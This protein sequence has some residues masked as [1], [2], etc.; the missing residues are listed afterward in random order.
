MHRLDWLYQHYWGG[1]ILMIIF[2]ILII[3]GIIWLFKNMT[4]TKESDE[5]DMR[6]DNPEEVAR[7][8]YA[9]G[10]IDKEELEE[11]LKNLKK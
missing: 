3:F 7:R 6:N 1:S 8:R 2:W 10:E 4:N 5:W 9:K 11:I